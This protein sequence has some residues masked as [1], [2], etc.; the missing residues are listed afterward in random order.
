VSE[1]NSH[2]LSGEALNDASGWH[3]GVEGSALETDGSLTHASSP[4][5]DDVS[6]ASVLDEP[7]PFLHP[8]AESAPRSDNKRAI[9]LPS[10]VEPAAVVRALLYNSTAAGAPLAA[11]LWL[12]DPSS[13]TLRLVHAE[14]SARPDS[15]PVPLDG[16]VLGKALR[17]GVAQIEPVQRLR[18]ASADAVVW[19]YAL[20]LS[21]GELRGV[22]AVD[23]EGP[24][25][26][27]LERFTPI[28][29]AMRGTLS[30]ALALHVARVE[31]ASARA[32]GDSTRDLA[33]VLDPDDVVSTALERAIAI[34]GAQTGSVMLLDETGCMRI[35]TSRG[36][37]A[38][39]VEQACVAE[40]EGIAGWVLA[41][42]QSLIVEDLNDRGRRS[43]RHGVRSAVSVPVGDSDGVL[44][45][46]NVGSTSFQAKLSRSNLEALE[47]IGRSTA[48][49]LRNARAVALAH[50][51]YFDT[52]K[53][54]AV[55]MEAKDPYAY[56]ATARVTEL[57]VALA[58]AAGMSAKEL[59]ALRVAALLHDIGMSAA[60]DVVTMTSRQLSTVEWGMLK[61]H[62]VIAAEILSQAP[63][64]SDAVPIVFHHHEHYD[65]GG[66][67]S[68]IAGDK[69]PL[70][71]RV[72]AVAD[73]FVALTSDR[74]YRSARSVE[75]ALQAVLEESGSQFDPQVVQSL[76]ELK[77]KESSIG[78]NGNG[79]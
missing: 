59:D 7:L 40:G 29:G 71:A 12:A 57:A 17:R 10:S 33:K 77:S 56:G 65:G 8:V 70:G 73:A 79:S 14:G 25:R 34:S 76:I 53:A 48:A 31:A 19:R 72:L 55:A 78:S 37:P 44:G 45:V 61:V 43:R 16:T 9:R 3:E 26:P 5:E 22:A 2:K 11:H 51:L 20:P 35:I 18:T 6:T 32:L 58:R 64:L 75:D 27:N 1:S 42:G 69:I 21:A 41:S 50:D 66:Y 46:L 62:P 30:G 15:T 54:L 24:R 52:L 67:V 74:P 13:E 23:F 63:S 68:G 36:L 47:S 4:E 28:A 60:G 38:E 49:A 39:V